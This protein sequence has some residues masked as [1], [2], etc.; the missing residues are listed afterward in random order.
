M[1]ADEVVKGFDGFTE[2]PQKRIVTP[3]EPTK[4]IRTYQ[5]PQHLADTF[6]EQLRNQYS[7]LKLVNQKGVPATIEIELNEEGDASD[8][9]LKTIA[10]VTW[11]LNWEREMKDLRSHGWFNV[12]GAAVGVMEEIDLAIKSKTGAFSTDWDAK[13]NLTHMND[14]RDCKLKG[15]NQYMAFAPTVR[16]TLVMGRY[17]K[18]NAPAVMTTQIVGWGDITLPFAAGSAQ[19][20]SSG[21]LDQPVLYEYSAGNVSFM[22]IPVNQ[23]LVC[24]VQRNFTRSTKR[25]EM[26]FEWLGATAYIGCLYSGGTSEPK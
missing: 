22:A 17:T 13:S 4:L 20:P 3:G 2:Q 11:S 25:Y 5:G 6:E 24:P 7:I 18:L 1:P 23:W 14:Y 10:E 8:P 9:D 12:S 15:I 21:G 19:N 26:D 16:A